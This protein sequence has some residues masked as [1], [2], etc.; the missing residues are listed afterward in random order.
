MGVRFGVS[1][2]RFSVFLSSYYLRIQSPN[3]QLPVQPQVSLCGAM[4][5]SML[6]RKQT[7]ETVSWPQ[8]N[9]SFS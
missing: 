2:S 7:S 3:S 8:G 1:N 5:P 9:V 4:L 6:I